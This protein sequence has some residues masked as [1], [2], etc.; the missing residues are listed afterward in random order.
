ME[1]QNFITNTANYQQE[2]KK[3]NLNVRKHS[4]RKLIVIK[5]YKNKDYELVEN[6]RLRYCRGA[7]INT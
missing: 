5:Y 2:L 6:H 4:K 1:L 3:Y 7:V